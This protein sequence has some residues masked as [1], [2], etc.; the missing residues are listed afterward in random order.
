MITASVIFSPR[1]ASA[2]AFSFWRIMALISGGLKVLPLPS[3]TTTPS[4]LGSFSTW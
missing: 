4:D 3:L 1:Y 2:S